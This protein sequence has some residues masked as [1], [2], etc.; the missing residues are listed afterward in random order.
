LTPTSESKTVGSTFKVTV[1]VDSGADKV[2][3]IDLVGTFDAT[4]LEIESIEKAATLGFAYDVT[5]LSPKKDNTAGTF[6]MTLTPSS[7]SALTGVVAKGDLVVITFKGKAVGSGA[8]N[9]TCTAN[10]VRETNVI[11]DV[12]SDVVD[13]ATNQSGLYTITAASDGGSP[14]A[15]NRPTPLPTGAK[16]RTEL[17]KT[18]AVETTVLL[19][20]A[21]IISLAGVGLLR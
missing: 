14:A 6:A 17:P 1:G 12:A 21:G 15:T 18:G 16:G 8:V 20:L 11:N 13:C 9:F 19:M 7:D 3:G 2:I 5:A 10:S 4:K